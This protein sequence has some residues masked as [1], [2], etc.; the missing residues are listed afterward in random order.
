MF[1]HSPTLS[2]WS[3]EYPTR[4]AAIEAF[5]TAGDPFTPFYILDAVQQRAEKVS[6][7]GASLA[8]YVVR[9]G[10]WVRKAT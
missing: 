8:F 3:G 2:P 10:R 1:K 4:V 7:K 5:D 6:P 9:D